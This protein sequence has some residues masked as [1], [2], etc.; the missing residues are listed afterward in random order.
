MHVFCWGRLYVWSKSFHLSNSIKST[1]AASTTN[2]I[3]DAITI[4]FSLV[5]MTN[6]WQFIKESYFDMPGCLQW[7]VVLLTLFFFVQTAV[8]CQMLTVRIAVM[9]R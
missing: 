5:A 9:T 1:H 4:I 6:I 8:K 7:K 3:Q 2:C